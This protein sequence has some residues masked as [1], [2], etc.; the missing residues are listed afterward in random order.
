MY[1]DG[2]HCGVAG[3][4][5]AYGILLYDF[6]HERG[7]EVVGITQTEEQDARNGRGRNERRKDGERGTWWSSFVVG[8]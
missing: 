5:G 6:E 7:L 3:T 8:W 1:I 4:E 2:S